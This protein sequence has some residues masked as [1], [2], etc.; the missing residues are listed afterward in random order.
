[1]ARIDQLDVLSDH[2]TIEGTTFSDRAKIVGVNSS[3]WGHGGLPRYVAIC[4]EGAF[5]LGATL[6]I[7]L[8]GYTEPDLTDAFVINTTGPVK[9]A[10]IEQGKGW[11]LLVQPTGRKYKYICLKY[12]VADVGDDA[13]DT[14]EEGESMCPTLPMLGIPEPKDN[15]F[16]SF[17]TLAIDSQITY[18]YANPDFITA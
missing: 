1:M 16:T 18:P 15:T 8:L 4:C 2:Q 10:D 3:D 14:H 9:Q 12:I 6:E 13:D 5:T 17:I 11:Y 7:K